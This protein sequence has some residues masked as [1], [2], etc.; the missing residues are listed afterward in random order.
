MFAKKEQSCQNNPKNSYTERKA[1][2]KPSGYSSSLSCS[3]D[4]T[5]NRR[6]FYRREDCIKKF[7]KDLKELAIEIINYEEKEMIPLADK[8][9]KFYEEQKVYHMC[10]RK[11]CY[12]KN[13]KNEYDL[14]HKARDHCHYTGKF[15][16]AAHNICNLRYK[17]PKKIPIVFHNDSTYDYHFITKQLAEDVKGKFECLGENTEKYIFGTS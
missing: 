8:E 5:K 12:D 15:K 4:E 1:K 14:Y 2:H 16:G 9:I 6:K 11:F 17:V 13:K 7:Y 10:K 3:F